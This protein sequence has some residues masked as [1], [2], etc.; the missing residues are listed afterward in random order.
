MTPEAQITAI[1]SVMPKGFLFGFKWCFQGQWRIFDP[2]NDLNAMHEAENVLLS[3]DATYS[4]RNFYASLLGSITLN[5]N[6]RGW[7]PL[8]NDDCFPILHATAAQR[9]EAFLRTLNLWTD[10]Q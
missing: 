6:G 4:Q 9:A 8:S 1:C 7:Q 10:E 5:D 3:D 2:L